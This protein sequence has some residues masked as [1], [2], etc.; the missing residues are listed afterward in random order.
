[1]ICNYIKFFP[2][3]LSALIS[4]ENERKNRFAYNKRTGM[5]KLG[6]WATEVEILATA[7][8]LKRDIITFHRGKWQRYSYVNTK[9]D[10]TIYLDNQ[11]AVHF[12]VILAP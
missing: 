8:C 2:G 12:N 9:S 11:S 1:M 5:N 3:R 4:R 7:K 6:E 10:D